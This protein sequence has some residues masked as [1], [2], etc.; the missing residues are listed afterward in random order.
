MHM[1]GAAFG[2]STID[3]NLC[4]YYDHHLEPG[5][6]HRIDRSRAVEVT[7][8][9]NATKWKAWQEGLNF[10]G[11][12]ANNMISAAARTVSA[13]LA[14]VGDEAFWFAPYLSDDEGNV[15]LMGNTMIL[16]KG[17]W[18]VR[19]TTGTGYRSGYRSMPMYNPNDPRMAMMDADVA[20]QRLTTIG[21]QIAERL[22]DGDPLEEP[23][24][25]D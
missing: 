4:A 11:N 18:A 12:F 1:H 9:E 8:L 25:R 14:G 22:P 21:Q 20:Q 23:D 10:S 3:L 15:G 2:L 5:F 6:S 13:P 16:R 7:S 19:V 24:G 17:R